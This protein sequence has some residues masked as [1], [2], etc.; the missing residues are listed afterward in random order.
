MVTFDE[1]QLLQIPPHLRHFRCKVIRPNQGHTHKSRLVGL[2]TLFVQQRNGHA[3]KSRLIH[4][5]CS[6]LCRQ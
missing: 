2:F 4:C 6:A 1:A 5:F 3:T